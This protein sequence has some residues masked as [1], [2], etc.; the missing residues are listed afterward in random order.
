MMEFTQFQDLTKVVCLM[1]WSDI[2]C[3]YGDSLTVK[4]SDGASYSGILVDFEIDYDGSYGGDSI[5]L[6]IPEFQG[7]TVSFPESDIEEIIA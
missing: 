1:K 5:S 4:T 7:V 2:G 6:R 3:G